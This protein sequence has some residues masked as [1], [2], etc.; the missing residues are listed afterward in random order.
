MNG[1]LAFVKGRCPQCRKGRVFKFPF[2]KISKFKPIHSHCEN[3]GVRFESEPGFF[4]GAMYFGYAINVALIITIGFIHFGLL[5][6]ESITVYG[7]VILT[8]VILLIPFNFRVSRLLMM[9]IAAP[10]RKYKQELHK[11]APSKEDA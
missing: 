1:L 5:G 7:L 6:S 11:K 10:Y 4:W 3:C 8:V 9:Y 2:L